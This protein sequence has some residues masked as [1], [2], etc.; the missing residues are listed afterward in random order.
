MRGEELSKRRQS[1]LGV[2]RGEHDR[3]I[4]GDA[5]CPEHRLRAAVFAQLLLRRTQR[6]I[7]EEKWGGEIL[8]SRRVRGRDAKLAQLDLRRRPRQIQRTLRGMRVI[9]PVRER[10]HLLA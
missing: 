9:V 3:P 6:R 5:L 10:E 2:D 7:P 8:K 4:S 1:I